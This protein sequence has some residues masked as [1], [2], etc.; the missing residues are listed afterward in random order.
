MRHINGINFINAILTPY[1]RHIFISGTE[2]Y[3]EK[4]RLGPKMFILQ[5]I[6]NNLYL[7]VTKLYFTHK[8]PDCAI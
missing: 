2:F 5:K 3:G 4:D 1:E 8:I 6:N 7:C